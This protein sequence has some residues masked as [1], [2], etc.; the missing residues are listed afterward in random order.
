MTLDQ[1]FITA[2][3]HPETSHSVHTRII[4]NHGGLCESYQRNYGKHLAPYEIM[5]YAWE[6]LPI[7]IAEFDA[8]K[9]KA[10]TVWGKVIR[11]LVTRDKRDS[12][13]VGGVKISE[14]YSKYYSG[15]LLDD[16]QGCKYDPFYD[17]D[18]DSSIISSDNADCGCNS[19]E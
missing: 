7:A 5:G 16:A 12:I 10:T 18:P 6:A 8:S 13:F 14:G 19:E 3:E 15:I 1:L 9:G 2:R 17:S 4:R 11:R